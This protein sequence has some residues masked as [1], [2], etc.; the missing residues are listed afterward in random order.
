MVNHVVARTVVVFISIETLAGL[1]IVVVLI[2][3]DD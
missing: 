2:V 1:V 3:V